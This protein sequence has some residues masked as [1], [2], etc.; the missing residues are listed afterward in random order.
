MVIYNHSKA[1][2]KEKEIVI[3]KNYRGFELDVLEDG[4]TFILFQ[5]KGD[6]GA[7]EEK[8]A[9]KRVDNLIARRIKE[10]LI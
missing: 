2:A 10:A 1:R 5:R 4:F 6:G 7:L 3:M 8:Y 9:K